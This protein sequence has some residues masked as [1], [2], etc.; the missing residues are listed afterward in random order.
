MKSK[1]NE[2][3]DRFK[4]WLVAKS[5]TQSY[6]I[7]YHETFAPVA[8]LNTVRVLLSLATNLDWSL[9]QLDVK[10][11]FLNGD[12]K[13]ELYMEILQGL[14]DYTNVNKVCKLKK[15]L[16]GLK[17]SP[18]AWFNRFT[19]AL[20]RLGYAKCQVDHTLFIKHL[21]HEKASILIVYVDDIVI[22]SDDEGETQRLKQYLAKGFEIKDLGSLQYFL[23][24]E[25]AWSRRGISVS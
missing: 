9:H 8:K 15:F 18:R 1:A 4:A 11:V 22:T 25:M 2:S 23:G 21:T 7:D 16:Y 24:M 3:I 10:N 19:K 14:E 5:Y 6:G 12:L 20:R 17:R 13:E